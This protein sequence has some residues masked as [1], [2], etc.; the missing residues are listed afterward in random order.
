MRDVIHASSKCLSLRYFLFPSQ[1]HY[2]LNPLPMFSRLGFTAVKQKDPVCTRTC[3]IPSIVQVQGKKDKE[4]RMPRKKMVCDVC[5]NECKKGEGHI[6]PTIEIIK[7]PGYWNIVAGY[8]IMLDLSKI[9]NT[10]KEMVKRII[11]TVERLASFKSGWWICDSC[12]KKIGDI[13]PGIPREDAQEYLK[14]GVT[15]LLVALAPEPSEMDVARAIGMAV[16]AYQKSM[17]SSYTLHFT[18]SDYILQ[19]MRENFGPR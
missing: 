14:T 2:T 12:M 16:K 10:E 18:E 13:D 1:L 15:P 3:N 11:E 8:G 5:N 17:G 7:S 9:R 4:R 6:L 19:K